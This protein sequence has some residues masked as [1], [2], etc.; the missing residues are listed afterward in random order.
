M[1]HISKSNKLK[2]G[3]MMVALTSTLAIS[4]LVLADE[5]KSVTAPAASENAGVKK[6]IQQQVTQN[7]AIAA[8]EKK[9]NELLDKINQD[10]L[11]GFNKVGEATKLLGEGKEKEAINMLATATGKFDIVLAENPDAGLMPIEAGVDV[12]ALLTTP[13]T[14]EAQVKLAKDL[15]SD[16]RVQAARAVLSPL[17]DEIVTRTSYLPMSTYP[18]AIKL[19]SKALVAGNKEEALDILA[20]ALSTVVTKVSVI[21]LALVRAESM[22]VAASA[23]DKEADKDKAMSLL[24]EAEQQ[25]KL[26]VALGYTDKHS[27]AYKDISTQIKAVKKE[28]K[29]SNAVEKLYTKLKTS[30]KGLLGKHSEVQEVKSDKK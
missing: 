15:L 12:T 11:D 30:V 17:S 28:A 6:D 27:E 2:A 20:T 5:S 21:P 16:S 22:I 4:P 26:A 9:Q 24:D 1:K 10:V 29:G 8:Q 14:V 19:A 18:D 23:L 7:K 3:L 13:E 25:L